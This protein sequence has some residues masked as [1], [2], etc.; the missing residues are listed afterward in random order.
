MS[1]FLAPTIAILL[2]AACSQ[3]PAAPAH[4]DAGT[5]AGSATEDVAQGSEK[6]TRPRPPRVL[7]SG[8]VLPFAHQVR[9]NRQEKLG[10]ATKRRVVVEIQGIPLDQADEQIAMAVEKNGYERGERTDRDN[11]FIVIYTGPDGSEIQTSFFNGEGAE[12]ESDDATG[13]VHVTWIV[14]R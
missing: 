7:P 3:E 9:A 2:L 11:G 14:R 10:G 8:F 13:I 1:R 5:S 12:L 4:E 6:V